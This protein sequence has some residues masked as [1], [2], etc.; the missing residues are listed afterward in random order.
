MA[1][2]GFLCVPYSV[3]LLRKAEDRWED[4]MALLFL[5]L[6]ATTFPKDVFLHSLPGN[7]ERSHLTP[8]PLPSLAGGLPRPV[9]WGSGLSPQ[10]LEHLG[11]LLGLRVSH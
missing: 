8:S 6:C 11:W 10:Q 9:F 1:G 4:T 5:E 2:E 3:L 7:V